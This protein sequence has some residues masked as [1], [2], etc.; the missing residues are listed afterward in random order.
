MSKRRLVTNF[1]VVDDIT[2]TWKTWTNHKMTYSGLFNRE[3][4]KKKTDRKRK[5]KRK[6]KEKSETT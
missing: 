5:R 4:K 6:R 1:N 2:V 3:K